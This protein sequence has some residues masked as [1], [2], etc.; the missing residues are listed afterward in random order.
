MPLQRE[1]EIY[2]FFTNGRPAAVMPL[3]FCILAI[4]SSPSSVHAIDPNDRSEDGHE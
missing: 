4:S 3:L 2:F 1:L